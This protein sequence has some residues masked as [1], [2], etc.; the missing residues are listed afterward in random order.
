MRCTIISILA[1]DFRCALVCLFVYVCVHMCV[2]V[3]VSVCVYA[4]FSPFSNC[5]KATQAI[6]WP[7]SVLSLGPSQRQGPAGIPVS[8]SKCTPILRLLSLISIAIIHTAL[9]GYYMDRDL[10]IS[11]FT[12]LVT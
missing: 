11:L 9:P 2:F 12:Y 5:I 8:V 6:L 3:Y 7:L 1:V 4:L 10:H